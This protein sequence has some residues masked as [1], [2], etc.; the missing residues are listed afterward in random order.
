[1][2]WPVKSWTKTFV[3]PKSNTFPRQPGCKPASIAGGV[4]AL[5]NPLTFVYDLRHHR[6]LGSDATQVRRLQ[7]APKPSPQGPIQH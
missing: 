2:V 4:V 3:R 6:G 7:K 5:N 1:L